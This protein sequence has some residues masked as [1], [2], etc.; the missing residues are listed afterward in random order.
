MHTHVAD[1]INKSFS[2]S[3]QNLTYGDNQAQLTD[4][5]AAFFNRCFRPCVPIQSTHLSIVNGC[6]TALQNLSWALSDPGDIILIGRPFYRGIP[7]DVCRRTGVE[8]VAVDTEDCD[9]LGMQVLSR[10]EGEILRQISV[11]ASPSPKTRGSKPPCNPS[12]SFL[13]R[14]P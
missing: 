12:T 7:M 10:F 4:V 1:R 9:P 2:I 5:F 13:G 14:A 8:L 6:T 3:E 11:W